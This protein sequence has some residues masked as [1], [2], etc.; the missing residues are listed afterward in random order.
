M[1]LNIRKQKEQ[2]S[3][4]NGKKYL[5]TTLLKLQKALKENPLFCDISMLSYIADSK[6]KKK[7]EKEKGTSRRKNNP[8]NEE[9]NA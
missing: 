9:I 1:L 6:R 2:H 5:F 7:N 4:Y 8:P 3:D